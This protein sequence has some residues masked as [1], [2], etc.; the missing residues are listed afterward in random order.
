MSDQSSFGGARNLVDLIDQLA[1][2]VPPPPVSMVPQTAGWWILAFAVIVALCVFGYRKRQAYH[3][4]A[5]RR[6]ALKEIS[7]AG[8]DIE[9]L[10]TILRRT[11]LAAYPRHEVASLSGEAWLSFLD[12]SAGSKVFSTGPGRALATAPYA[13]TAPADPSL[14]AAIRSWVSDHKGQDML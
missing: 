14:V 12:A 9:A 1:E 11:A 13:N 10:A 8:Q 5:Y 2:P 3:R 4:D 6:A 7:A